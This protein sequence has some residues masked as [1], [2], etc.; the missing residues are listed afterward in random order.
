M[1]IIGISGGTGAGKSTVCAE[2]EKRG[3]CIIDADRISRQVSAYG[4]S[5]YGEIV[6]TFGTGILAESGEID[7][8]ALGRIVFNDSER[9]A[10]L[11]RITHRHI[12]EEMKKQLND[13][14]AE[15]AVLDVPLLFQSDFPFNCDLTVAVV[16]AP[17][18]RLARIM[19]RDGISEDAA[20]LRM[21]NQMTDEEYA[22]CADMC[23]RN[24]GVGVTAAM[25]AEKIVERVR[26]IG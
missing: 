15:F 11:N 18:V 9:L 14:D 26:N 24:D 4:G 5:A 16:A 13:C 19:A 10:T 1:K 6:E 8:K 22:E 23:V 7:R 20:R 12:F 2:L 21:K 3:A 17:E 25:L